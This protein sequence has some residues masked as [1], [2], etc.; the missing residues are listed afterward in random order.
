MRASLIFLVGF[1]IAGL[2]HPQG[3]AEPR[4]EEAAPTL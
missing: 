4:P 2:S 3:F 1:E